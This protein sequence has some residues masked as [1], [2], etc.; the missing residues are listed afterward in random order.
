MRKDTHFTNRSTHRSGVAFLALMLTNVVITSVFAQQK[1]II[2][3]RKD[4][5]VS[6]VPGVTTNGLNSG[7]YFNKFSINLLS[8]LSAGNTIFEF[9]TISNA[10]IF[11]SS[12][13]QIAGIANITGVNKT[14]SEPDKKQLSRK[15]LQFVPG[16]H[17]IQVAGILNY[18]HAD[19]RGLQ[20]AG[21]LNSTVQL[22]GIQVAG[23]GNT[24]R[25]TVNGLQLAGLYN[26]SGEA[27]SG[28]QIG[29]VFNL[30]DGSFSGTQIGFINKAHDTSGK[31]STPPT[32][33]RG[34]QLGAINLN[35]EMD[36]WQLGF[37]NFGGK[38]RG[39]QIGLVNFFEKYPTKENVRLGIP[40]GLINFGSRGPRYKVSNSEMFPVSIEYSTGQCRNC[41]AAQS[42]MPFDGKNQVYFHNSIIVSAKPGDD[43][44]AAGYGFQRILFNKVA[45]ATIP[46]NGKRLLA[47]GIKFR[48]LHR[49]EGSN[50]FN[51]L[52]S[53]N[54]D[55]GK[56]VGPGHLY[57]S[58]TLNFF[59]CKEDIQ[60]YHLPSWSKQIGSSAEGNFVRSIWPGYSF[61]FTF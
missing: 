59:V 58:I 23:F 55:Y 14:L 31:N 61:G 13:I 12:G 36:G 60:V 38:C 17:G 21:L 32:R 19:T 29:T 9:G 22:S 20:F 24:A 11:G 40:I 30:V 10:N 49:T 50:A 46:Q 57:G 4:L 43:I 2:F 28:I 5:Q 56:R 37:L 54:F 48:Y 1:K 8:G 34:L 42:E 26:L 53:L 51:L 25:G 52:T 33:A 39:V 47:H 16:F 18:V 7:M 35:K 6:V 45:M 41:S 44:W 3:M 15:E 27:M